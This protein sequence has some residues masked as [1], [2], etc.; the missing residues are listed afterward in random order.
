MSRCA[1]VIVT[2]FLLCLEAPTCDA[3]K[4]KRG[5]PQPED[6]SSKENDLGT[7]KV[8]LSVSNEDG[9]I[10]DSGDTYTIEDYD[11]EKHSGAMGVSFTPS[12]YQTVFGEMDPKAMAMLE[13]VVP[14]VPLAMTL[15]LDIARILVGDFQSQYA[16]LSVLW[17]ADGALYHA[18]LIKKVPVLKDFAPHLLTAAVGVIYLLYLTLARKQGV[19]PILLLLASV[20]TFCYTEV[21][22]RTWHEMT[23][24]HGQGLF[25]H[26]TL[27][28]LDL[29]LLMTAPTPMPV[30]RPRPTRRS[31]P[32]PVPTGKGGKLL[33]GTFDEQAN[34]AEFQKAVD[35]WRSARAAEAGKAKTS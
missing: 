12:S 6:L 17:I 26:I 22:G 18:G 34:K 8:T 19:V 23:A 29:V 28:F 9:K 16:L 24:W 3:N 21:Q 27:F 13:L 15:L 20:A 2:L 32:P 33:E 1:L 7:A 10:D 4:G 14:N 11:P 5:P 30:V 31:S 35:D 25:T